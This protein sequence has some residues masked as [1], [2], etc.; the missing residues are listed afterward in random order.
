MY[1]QWKLQ[2]STAERLHALDVGGNLQPVS[3]SQLP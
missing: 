3:N 1:K 2:S